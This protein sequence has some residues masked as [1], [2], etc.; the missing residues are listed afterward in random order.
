MEAAQVSMGN[1]LQ[2][3]VRNKFDFEVNRKPW[4][5]YIIFNLLKKVT[6]LNKC[7]ATGVWIKNKEDLFFLT[8]FC[9]WEKILK[10]LIKLNKSNILVGKKILWLKYFLKFKL[11]ISEQATSTSKPFLMK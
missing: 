6:N 10:Y 9:I 7:E 5:K 11:L 2:Q 1:S 4:T 3:L 8:K